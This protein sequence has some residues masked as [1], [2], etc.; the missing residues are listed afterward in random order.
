MKLKNSL[1]LA[2]QEV[3][4]GQ[5]VDH[6]SSLYNVGGYFIFKGNFD[7]DIFI[8][9]INNLP[10]F[11]DIFNIKFD[12]SE[13]EPLCYLKEDVAQLV[14]EE[15][16]FSKDSNP[17]KTAMDW[18]Q[19]QFNTAFDLQS[20][21]LY[22]YTLIKIADDE[23]WCL[24]C[25]HHLL[26]DGYS[27][28]IKL[29]H[30]MEEYD[31][32]TN[33]EEQSM[34]EGG[35]PS[36]HEAILNSLKYLDSDSYVKDAMY[37]KNKYSVLPNSILNHSKE[38]KEENGNRLSF[39]ISESDRLLY[40]DL[41]A[42][43]KA[44][45]QQFTI[46]ALLVYLG[47]TTND[48]LFSFGVPIHNRGSRAERKTLGMFS[49]VLPFKGIYNEDEVL[50]DL[51]ATLKKTQREDYRHRSYPIS[52]LNR[53][54][55]LMSKKRKQL[56]DIIVNYEPFAFPESLSSGLTIQTKHLT[57]ILDLE[58][59]LSIRWC[60]YGADYP[61]ELKV[62][63]QEEYFT[64]IQIEGI[65]KSIFHILSQ[66]E[67]NLDKPL[68]DVSIIPDEEKTLLLELFNNKSLEYPKEQTVI[69]VFIQQAMATPNAVAVL[70]EE[71]SLTY[72]ELDEKSNQLAHYLKEQGVK[73]ETLVPI[74]IDKSLEMIVGILG[75]LKSGGAYVPIDPGYPQSR[76][77]FILQ[78][79]NA[80]IVIT[81]SD[82]EHL[83]N[84]NTKRYK[85]IALDTI[86]TSLDQIS[87]TPLPERITPDQLIYVI[88]TSGTTGTPKGV[89]CE[90][91]GIMNVIQ[92]QIKQ[93]GL[94]AE[95]TTLQFASISFDAFT[96]ELY[97]S[98]LSGGKLVMVHKDILHSQEE[99][100]LFL[101]KNKITVATLPP[102]YQETL[103]DSLLSLRTII[104]AGEAIQLSL[105]KKFQSK[106]IQVINGYGPTEN[107]VCATMSLTPLYTD[108]IAT[109][110]SAL[111]NTSVYILS[112]ALELLPIGVVGELCISGTQL[113]RGYLNRPE[114]TQNSFVA[115]PFK[116]GE[117][118][119]KTGDLA[120][121][122]PDG[123]IEFI[124]RKD[125][126]VKIRGYRIE[127]EEIVSTLDQLSIIK[128]SVVL[129]LPDT[130]GRKRLV[131]YVTLT[132]AVDRTEIQQHLAKKLPEYMVPNTYV[133]ME[134]FPLTHNGKIDKK[135]LP[136]PEESFTKTN[137]YIAPTT[138]IEKQLVTIW[139]I[140]LGIENIGICDN[141][142]ELGG[143]SI[144]AIQL[145]GKSKS[146]GFHYKVKDIFKYQTISKIASHLQEEHLVITESGAL[147]GEVGLHPI[148]RYFF[149][150]NYAA[151]NHYNQSLLFTV[152]KSIS[153]NILDSSLSTLC[154]H[155]DA[156]RLTYQYTDGIS[157]PKQTY[158]A[159]TSPLIETEV[160][161][162]SE[163][164]TISAQYQSDLDITTGDLIRFVLIR[165][166]ESETHNRLCIAIHHLAVDG[167]SWRIL[168]E[169]LITLLSNPSNAP[170]VVLPTKG[171][172]Y[173]QWVSK[174]EEYTTSPSVQSEYKYWKK[175]VANYTSIPEDIPSTTVSTYGD[176]HTH[177][178]VLSSTQ[179][180]SLVKDIHHAY[181]TEINDIILSALSVA[182]K[183]WIPAS[184]I[185][186]GLEGHGREELFD[187]VD[188]SRT[189]GWFTSLYPV[190]LSIPKEK[191]TSY[192]ALL[193]STKDMLRQIPNR[194]IGYGI[195]RHL[196]DSEN[197]REDLSV[198]YEDLI[199][200]YLG[201][202]DSSLSSENTLLGFAKESIAPSV[203][204]SNTNPNKLVIDS[205]IVDG[206]LE[207][208][209]SYDANRYNSSTIKELSSNY[210]AALEAIVAHCQNITKTIKTPGDYGLPATLSHKKLVDFKAAKEKEQLANIQDIY[211]LS[212]L[213]E[214]ILFHSLYD[215]EDTAYI[216]QFYCDLIGSFSRNSFDKSWMH[217][218]QQ[219]TILRTSIY[220]EGLDI[221]VQCV[222]D[223]LELPIQEVDYSHLPEVEQE[224]AFKLFLEQDKKERF[225]L[226][227][228]P[229]FRITLFH[230]GAN[231]TRMAFTNH[232]ILWD[233]W[234][235]SKLISNFMEC[236][237]MFDA[238][239][240]LPSILP[241][242]Y[243]THIHHVLSKNT[244]EGLSYWKEY[245]SEVTTATY[246]PFITNA[247]DRNK[248]FG[249][250]ERRSMLSTTL[251]TQLNTF[252]EQHHI[253]INTVLQGVWSFLLSKYTS[254][255]DIVF[256]ATVSGRDSD[257]EGIEDRV[258]LYINT[259]PVCS[260]I[261][262]QA[263]VSDWLQEL[264][265]GHTTAR[266]EYSYLS[267]STIEDQSGISGSLFDTIMVFE[268]YPIEHMT[269]DAETELTIENIGSSESTN[270]TLSICVFNTPE[271]LSIK[272]MY[273][274]RLLPEDTMGMIESH[275]KQA[276]ESLVSGVETIEEISYI[277]EDEKTTLLEVFNNT[278]IPY[279]KDQT[280]IDLFNHQVKAAPEAIA[281]V[282]EG[283]SLTYK[284]LDEKSNQLAHYLQQQGVEKESLVPICVHRSVDMI[285]GMLGVVKAG[286]AYV[287]IDPAYPQERIDFILSDT[288]AAIVIAESNTLELFSTRSTEYKSITLDTS[289]TMINTFSTL[290]LAVEI[291]PEQLI[292]VIYT[293]GTTGVPKGVLLTH[294]NVVRLFY[295]DT[296][297][298]NFDANDVWTMFHSY[299]FDFS[300]WEMYGALLFGGKL[301]VVPPSCT[302]DPALFS[303]LI[304]EQ[305]VTVL[306]Q[307][308]T[309]FNGV[310]EYIINENKPHAI[311]YVIF[312]GEA[313]HP[314]HL[315][316]WNL[317]YP[318]CKLIN[319][320]GITETTVHVTYKEIGRTEIEAN[321]SNI[322]VPLPTLGIIILDDAFQP[323]P[324]GVIGEMYV[325]GSGVA[326]GY[327]NRESL[328]QERFVNLDSNNNTVKRFYRSGDLARITA[329]GELEYLGRK[330]HQVKIRGYRIELGEIESVLE[331]MPAIKQV[332]VIAKEDQ[333][334]SKQ[335]VTYVV[336]ES[337]IEIPVIE[338]HLHD[339]LPSYMIPKVYVF[340]KEFP[341]TSNGK[342]N[343][344]ALPAPNVGKI[345]T[346]EHSE[347]RNAVEKE[348]V[349]IYKEQLSIDHVGIKD[350]F[351]TIGGDSIKI[352]RL[353]SALNALFTTNISISAF[354]KNPTIAM[355]STL[356]S[357][358]KVVA[359]T[360]ENLEKI[361]TEEL[362]EIE[363]QVIEQHPSA[364]TIAGV[365]PMT[366][367]QFGMVYTSNLM[368]E[369]GI[370]GI[371]HD[372]MVIRVGALDPEL[373]QQALSL[374]VAKHEILRTSLH[375]YE[376]G[377]PVQIIHKE[378]PTEV[379]YEDIILLKEES[380]KMYV[381]R[382]LDQERNE[383]PF[384]I[385]QAP[386][387]R[388]SVFRIGEEDSIFIFQCHHAII[389]GWS[390][391][392]FRIELLN[393]Y[394]ELKKDNT[395]TPQKLS[396]GI[397]ESV[398]SDLIERR[399]DDTIHYWKE[400]LAGYNR[401]QI[402]DSEHVHDHL[403]KKYT[404]T[405]SE[406]IFEKCKKDNITPKG[407]FL[408]GYLYLISL[409]SV[410]KDITVGLV[411][412]R[413]PMVEDGDKILGCFLNTI[414]FR[415]QMDFATPDSWIGYIKRVES[416]LHE[417]KGKDRLSL[418]E[419]SKLHGENASNPFFDIIFN[420]VD[421]HIIGDFLQNKQMATFMEK[422]KET[423]F[424]SQGH[425]ETNTF[426]DFTV[427]LTGGKIEVSITQNR[428]IKSGHRLS[429]IIMYFDNFLKNYLQNDVALVNSQHIIPS[430]EQEQLLDN[431]DIDTIAIPSI[432]NNSVIN[433]FQAQA[434]KT[435]DAIAVVFENEK[436]TYKELNEKSNQLAHYLQQQG[437]NNQT[438]VP[439]CVD[440]SL[441]MIIGI[442]GI[443]KSGG[444]YVP[445]DPSYPQSRIDFII[446]DTSAQIV[447]TQKNLITN[448][449]KEDEVIQ[450]IC[451][452]GWFS[453]L[454]TVSSEKL[455]IG[456]SKD[457]LAYIIYTSGTT[458]TPKGVMI[459]HGAFFNLVAHQ[460]KYYAIHEEERILLFSNYV[461]D[462]SIEQIFISITTGASLYIPTTS[463][464]MDIEELKFYIT[465][466]KI[467]HVDAT[468]SFLE[469]ISNTRLESVKRVVSGGESCS[470]HLAKKLA[471][472]YDFYNA[473]GPTETTITSLMHQYK[474]EDI[475]PIGRPITNTQV[476][477]LSDTLNLVPIGVVGEL[478]I[479]GAGVSKGYLHMDELT[480]SKFIEDP[481]EQGTCLYKTG[482]L[483]KWLPNGTIAYIGRKD[484]QVK[485]RGYR[486]ELGEIE[487]ALD[488]LEE[489]KQSVVLAHDADGIGKQ[490]VA[491]ILSDQKVDIQYIKN[492]LQEKL[493]QY[494]IP[495]MYMFSDTFP[496]TITG[497]IDK[498]A[499]PEPDTSQ[500]N[501]EN[502]VAPSTATEIALANIWATLLGVEKIGAQDNFFELGGHSLLTIK[503]KSEIEVRLGREV[504]VQQIFNTPTLETYSKALDDGGK[505]DY[506]IALDT[507]AIFSV[508]LKTPAKKE[509][510][511]TNSKNILLTGAT[512]FVGIHLLESLLKN[513]DK[514]IY[515]MIRCESKIDGLERIQK[516]M[517]DNEMWSERY[518][519]QIEVIRG[520]LAKPNLGITMSEYE[521]LLEN[522]GNVVHN[523]TYMNHLSTYEDAKNV[524]VRGVEN[525]L[526]FCTSGSLKP[527]HFVS[528]ID[529]FS[530][531]G[532]KSDRHV[533]ELT[534]TDH[535]VHYNSGGYTSSKWIG[536]KL[537]EKASAIG[538]PTTIHRLG[539][540]LWDTE[541]NAYDRNQ[542]FYQLAESCIQLGTY[543]SVFGSNSDYPVI[544]V[545]TLVERL[546]DY[547]I[548]IAPKQPETHNVLH[549]CLEE[550]QKLSDLL[551]AYFV[552]QN[553]SLK[554]IDIKE[555]LQL[556]IPKDLSISW[557][558]SGIKEEEIDQ[559]VDAQEKNESFSLQF[560]CKQTTLLFDQKNKDKGEEEEPFLVAP[561]F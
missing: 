69:D 548:N 397:H 478:C 42:K 372:Q 554:K 555:W 402:L 129:A 26:I 398:I 494:M 197:I 304:L 353:I 190:C 96:S 64:K 102:S 104:S 432:E 540:V 191:E 112:E 383:N 541:T 174:L 213:Q 50:L 337:E 115:H 52:H 442:L 481:L 122:L 503:L 508:P 527:I 79:T 259:I 533:N 424:S 258:G 199:F 375:L 10:Y 234:S 184:K 422:M 410:E 35:A 319:M 489:V 355:L 483:A 365:Y 19:K 8:E 457:Q 559:T 363:T 542:W 153:A 252:A 507:E 421:F 151:Y 487:Y 323:V 439:I 482:D 493:P 290:P 16:D 437:V 167:V 136:A 127:L 148:Q 477:I 256:G 316:N 226:S 264:Q 157:F 219:H 458:G 143:D 196:S 476:Y 20:E 329:T 145:V 553:I 57:S 281:V 161:S 103:Q 296:P 85:C 532:Q 13:E 247:S 61:L 257:I 93:L 327:L 470:L 549:H 228:A 67:Y 49:S 497:K 464:I 511:I 25:L 250:K 454:T 414:P 59:P 98:L 435:P 358:N 195:L 262:D 315:K 18:M 407:L 203:G 152:S 484:D 182:L 31:R 187:G 239:G 378:I 141:F 101:S 165:T 125:D 15:L 400:K 352:I 200:N 2:Q 558:L 459:P 374:L 147:E 428:K 113:A 420:Y 54:L 468:P 346:S 72:K 550:P 342:I 461:F 32:Q 132:T 413:R 544:H 56:F 506:Q 118:L 294:T 350:N 223:Q 426:L 269:S 33:E 160:H 89:L 444:A 108:T 222:Y 418:L 522:I 430:G 335:L 510:A 1:H 373:M 202:L 308:P 336:K 94:S 84:Q 9:I 275:I 30:I 162:L 456:I 384:D 106:G 344:K 181:G 116:K 333:N 111:P 244:P 168:I 441:E 140:A 124:G 137:Q 210:I 4:Y 237:K 55:N 343:R 46:A 155:H 406:K 551:T 322:G 7:T 14:V 466:H 139:E 27:Y 361:V 391:S 521:L 70:Y 520:D 314:I 291:T 536:E 514:K 371:Y 3:Y 131:A 134:E 21:K 349:R 88:Y 360:V 516:K 224:A 502:Y 58:S 501:A 74:C 130:N 417:L 560:S 251:T 188:I 41:T 123:N 169:D 11:F 107:S 313:L 75:I 254:S 265:S 177:V 144:K 334:G 524:N 475:V 206:C 411:T 235:F 370:S 382:F 24:M 279:P 310:Q 415:S 271:G 306:N 303:K 463:C 62:D 38:G 171:T 499:L 460:S 488:Q 246:L 163:L 36:Y 448:F 205:M 180:Q 216:V 241:D 126:Q 393:T 288:K 114:L 364:T 399:N 100:Q 17:K 546:S 403:A 434:E 450:I 164:A 377:N 297:L 455:N 48:T 328:T 340:L 73:R 221:P 379:H 347:P 300:V 86:A 133:L 325:S 34:I 357:D 396:A 120:R 135:A 512:G 53:S 105:V 305:G 509:T 495:N 543:P 109:I 282:Y 255:P 311:R 530:S 176:T 472:N 218:M 412:H 496:T 395:Y 354:Y 504:P 301:V 217:L 312:G 146:Q 298:F 198:A 68:K 409:L 238:K 321:Q 128:Q 63:Y 286:G 299:T 60:D 557:M 91:K 220:A 462:A 519:Q 211:P 240:N 28:M 539:L 500:Y 287:P 175:V 389:D 117:R 138:A 172:S 523:A 90:H 82:L 453:E 307:T 158:G 232:H 388:I 547:I 43:T 231:R 369:K 99:M 332:L 204:T 345:E 324:K 561:E 47:K 467:T 440:R 529:V 338:A 12:F 253:T 392:N 274:D 44:S 119:Y 386:L 556:A 40:N 419:I 486:I 445:I 381:R 380:Q 491:Y 77:D 214:G 71:D 515:C 492:T 339:Q 404:K 270:Y 97:A 193:S 277:A 170:T 230:L 95:D 194:G 185:V 39:L 225:T 295:N 390:D 326:R 473:Y 51:I 474:G 278:E 498:K 545:N 538:L 341:M 178:S 531:H 293:S 66:F 449:T 518:T 267:L 348:I 6:E 429:N 401:L 443:L 451:L 285:I 183:D 276:L 320:Y 227:K 425:A 394:F 505:E 78:D 490:L 289:A 367:I 23:Y 156:L 513:T 471:Q 330:D 65:V 229:L 446:Q 537:V 248:V 83:F 201:D 159:F 436:L 242:Q 362:K 207:I 416:E 447:V 249:N 260:H 431:F 209:W 273:N 302:K 376:F 268:N 37:W 485:I 427:S 528:T 263:K 552:T 179:T 469:L 87:S 366:D 154:S 517:K 292:Y 272:M 29:N 359:S 438:L 149:E 452:D 186:I 423:S 465:L 192:A 284:E 45:L 479:K 173:R 212:A 22:N 150:Q 534:T 280:V 283:D 387:W 236:Y 525:V 92:N 356:I 243:S 166:P 480:Q 233:G 266:E 385:T 142:F 318:S 526:H 189:V 76:I 351:F 81:C 5:L 309:N 121:W 245:L 408:S 368:R 317:K 80:D 433:M 261:N 208:K 110:G 535:E 331:K 405:Y 215:Q